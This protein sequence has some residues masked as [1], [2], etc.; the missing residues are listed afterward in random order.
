VWQVWVRSLL[1]AAYPLALAISTRAKNK[2][3]DTGV[4]RVCVMMILSFRTQIAYCTSLFRWTRWT[5]V[6]GTYAQICFTQIRRAPA[7]S[8]Q[9][10]LHLQMHRRRRYER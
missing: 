10:L 7:A 5:K 4:L 1:L 9:A 8:S 6:V 2:W 3:R